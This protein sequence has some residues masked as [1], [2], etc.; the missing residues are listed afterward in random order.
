L[1]LIFSEIVPKTLGAN[2]WKVL[3]APAAWVLRVLVFI[4][5]PVTV[6]VNH[7][8]RLI[9]RNPAVP[10]VSKDEVLTSVRL[11]FREGAV[12]SSEYAIVENLF[13][14]KSVTVHDVMT[15]RTVVVWFAPGQTLEELVEDG[16]YLQ[17]SRIPL[18]DPRQERVVGIVLRRDIMQRLAREELGVP[19]HELANEPLFVAEEMSVFDLLDRFITY[20]VHLAAV[21]DEFGDFAGIVTMEDAIE[22]LLGREIVDETDRVVDM[23]ELARHKRGSSPDDITD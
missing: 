9:A 14:L 18:Y 8:A 20:K 21:L 11:G 2:Y 5:T 10:R 13:R 23:R 7:L 15:P 19:L 22:T 16:R 12:E 17:F 6:P 1:I 4:L 3:A